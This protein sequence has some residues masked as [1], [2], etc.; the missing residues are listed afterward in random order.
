MQNFGV[1]AR[2]G[3]DGVHSSQNCRCLPNYFSKLLAT[4]PEVIT[5]AD[6]MGVCRTGRDWMR[7]TMQLKNQQEARFIGK[8]TG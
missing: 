1:Y 3:M 4:L 7:C 8:F 5:F 2:E 6:C